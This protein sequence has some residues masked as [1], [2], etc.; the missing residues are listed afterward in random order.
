MSVRSSLTEVDLKDPL[1]L[2]DHFLMDEEALRRFTGEGPLNTDE[3]P[4]ISFAE[5]YGKKAWH[6]LASL[7]QF[8]T[9]ATTLVR[10]SELPTAIASRLAAG[11]RAGEHSLEGDVYRMRGD[12]EAAIRSYLQ[13]LAQNPADLTSAHFLQQLE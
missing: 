11:Y 7:R 13:A 10:E 5:S 8:R 1:H 12:P 3:R 4:Y 9:P 6:V 2:F